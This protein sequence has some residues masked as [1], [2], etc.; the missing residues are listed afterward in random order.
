MNKYVQT[1]L[2][3][4]IV[5]FI[6]SGLLLGADLLTA[7]LIEANEE[8]LLKSVILDASDVEY[9]FANIHDVFEDE[10]TILEEDNLIFYI[11]N[12]TSYISYEF[13]G[14][15]VWGD[16]IGIITLEDDFQTIVEISILQQEETPGLGGVVAEREYLET[17]EGKVFNP[18][19]IISKT[20]NTE[21]SNEVDSITGATRTSDAFQI[22][23][24]TSYSE[25]VDV[26][27]GGE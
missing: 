1:L 7:D 6:T 20:A 12:E 17:Y 24:N 14:G 4:F 9:T 13:K 8:A 27:Q 25:H 3:V 18:E 22:I 2:F 11:N 16:I 26:Y 5:G 21:L 19:I 23:L 10:I 15:G